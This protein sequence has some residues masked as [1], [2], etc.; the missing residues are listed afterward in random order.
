M[1]HIYDTFVLYIR[2]IRVVMDSTVET[3]RDFPLN[4]SNYCWPARFTVVFVLE[5]WTTFSFSPL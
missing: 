2:G 3:H 4:L 1:Y 5:S